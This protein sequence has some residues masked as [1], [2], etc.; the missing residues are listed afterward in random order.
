MTFAV[1]LALLGL[2]SLPVLWW[3]HR[4]MRRPPTV[5]MPSLMFLMDE[6]DARSLPKG[7]RID[8]SLLATLGAAALLSIA[9]AGP[10]VKRQTTGRVVRIVVDRGAMD[11]SSAYRQRVDAYLRTLRKSLGDEDRVVR[12][13]LPNRTGDSNYAAYARARRA[14]VEALRGVAL[15]GKAD[16]RVVIS[17]AFPFDVNADESSS[18]SIR[19]IALGSDDDENVSIVSVNA[20]TE[21]TS[22]SVFVNVRNQGD[23]PRSVQVVATSGSAGDVKHTTTEVLVKPGAHTTTTMDLPPG[24]DRVRLRLVQVS[25]EP[26]ADALAVDDDVWLL[27]REPLRVSIASTLPKVLN[28][29][30]RDALTASLGSDGWQEGGVDRVADISFGDSASSGQGD[31]RLRVAFV[32]LPKDEQVAIRRR[33]RFSQLD[34]PLL[35]DV[36]LREL[37]A[38]VWAPPKSEANHGLALASWQERQNAYPVIVLGD[39][40][41]L[42]MYLDASQLTSQLLQRPWFPLWID[43]CV[44]HVRGDRRTGPYRIEGLLDIKSSTLGRSRLGPSAESVATAVARVRTERISLRTP[45]IFAALALLLLLWAVPV[46]VAGKRRA[47]SSGLRI[48]YP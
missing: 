30:I 44:V 20:R 14:S 11:P 25:G 35:R 29:A 7:R 3:L 23:A 16:V 19:W 9:A 37:P 39:D 13:N 15:A 41:T 17:D 2:L 21:S 31:V 18:G 32:V 36:L 42:A 28:T 34:H 47:S 45:C 8:L 40:S 33:A 6:D 26:L 5:T 43:N 10:H 1:P 46:V 27:S 38:H 48:A 4:R 24:L 22:T 12:V